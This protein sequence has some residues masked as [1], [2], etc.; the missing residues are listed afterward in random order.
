[1]THKNKKFEIYE[2][3]WHENFELPDGLSS[4]SDI[5]VFL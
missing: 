5:L 1:M 3:S 4:V 2:P